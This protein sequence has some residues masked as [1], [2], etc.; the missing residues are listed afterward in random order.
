MNTDD[1][2]DDAVLSSF[3]ALRAC[4]VSRARAECL[5]RECHAALRRPEARPSGSAVIRGGSWRRR[6]LGPAI[7]GAWCAVYVFETI[8]RA[9]AFYRF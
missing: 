4:D 5:R 7:A 2:R 9:M 3:S 8:R 6:M 1:V